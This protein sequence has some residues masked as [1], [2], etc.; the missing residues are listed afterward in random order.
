M[1]DEPIEALPL[2]P[3]D[4]KTASQDIPPT[5][6]PAGDPAAPAAPAVEGFA[7]RDEAVEAVAVDAVAVEAKT[8]ATPASEPVS[9]STSVAKRPVDEWLTPP[10]PELSQALRNLRVWLPF[11]ANPVERALQVR[12]SHDL[13]RV[14]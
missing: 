2:V 13:N 14:G 10:R 9:Q 5:S 6:I 12:Y 8:T 3:A 7:L 1:P 4:A 11:L